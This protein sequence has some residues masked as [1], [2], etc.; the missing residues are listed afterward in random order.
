MRETAGP[1]ASNANTYGAESVSNVLDCH[2]DIDLAYAIGESMRTLRLEQLMREGTRTA[3]GI[4]S[5][6]RQTVVVIFNL[7]TH[8]F[9][10]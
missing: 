3:D 10:A 5:T 8:A 9:Y 1:S 6:E 4:I 7:F 2:G